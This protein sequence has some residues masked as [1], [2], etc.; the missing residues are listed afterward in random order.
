MAVDFEDQGSLKQSVEIHEMSKSCA[1][2]RDEY[3]GKLLNKYPFCSHLD[4]AITS[5]FSRNAR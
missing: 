4:D 3:E 1:V 5:R 2:M